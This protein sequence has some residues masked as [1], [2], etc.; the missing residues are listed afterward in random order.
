MHTV[1]RRSPPRLLRLSA[2]RRNHR[3]LL[4]LT[5]LAAL[6]TTSLTGFA[7]YILASVRI[8]KLMGG[9]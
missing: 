9:F 7:M 5:I 3:P 6:T 4:I 2:E 1:V 8:V